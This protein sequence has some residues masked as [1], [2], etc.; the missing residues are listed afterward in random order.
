MTPKQLFIFASVFVCALYFS[1][2][3]RAQLANLDK[4][5]RVLIERGLQIQAQSFYQPGDLG[6]GSYDFDPAPY[7]AANFTGI[8]WH[9]RP[10]N[11]SFASAYPA[12]RRCSRRATIRII[13]RPPMTSSKK[14]I[15]KAKTWGPRSCD[16]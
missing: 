1:T 11:T 3:I 15:A 10:V 4:G 9:Y 7:L 6:L 2:T 16:F 12:F 13:P 14:S 5:H 8:N